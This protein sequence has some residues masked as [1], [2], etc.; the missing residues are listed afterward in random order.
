MESVPS[1]VQWGVWPWRLQSY[2]LEFSRKVRSRLVLDGNQLCQEWT[3]LCVGGRRGSIRM[4][5]R[6]RESKELHPCQRRGTGACWGEEPVDL[7]RKRAG[8]LLLKMRDADGAETQPPPVTALRLAGTQAAPQWASASSSPR[9]QN[10]QFPREPAPGVSRFA[11][12][13][14]CRFRET[15]PYKR[16]EAQ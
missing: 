15:L 6:G 10:V 12:R 13:V 2:Q 11:Q 7:G 5:M 3:R 14:V 9:S 8:G 16:S 1:F 4:G